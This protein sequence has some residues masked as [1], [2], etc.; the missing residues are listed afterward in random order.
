MEHAE[1]HKE[2]LKAIASGSKPKVKKPIQPNKQSD[3]QS[4]SLLARKKELESGR[5]IIT[6]YV[7]EGNDKEVTCG[8]GVYECKKC[9]STFI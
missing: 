4:K 5:N 8:A 9:K 1:K 6:H 2:T 7:D 3:K